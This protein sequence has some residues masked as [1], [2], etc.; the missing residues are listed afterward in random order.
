MI[1]TA[2]LVP[3][4]LWA[5]GR[6][7]GFPVLPIHLITLLWTYSLQ[8]IAGHPEIYWYDAE[9]ISYSAGCVVMYAATATAVWL[10][11]AN[12]AVSPVK[13]RY[14]IPERRGFTI[15]ALSLAAGA[16]FSVLALEPIIVLAPGTFGIV[17]ATVLALASIATFIL[18][19]QLGQGALSPHQRAIF[20]TIALFYLV[21]QLATLFL[22][23]SIIVAAS[24][25]IGFTIGRHKVPWMTIAV[26]VLL[27]GFLHSGKSEMR[28]RYWHSDHPGVRIWELPQFFAE[29][30]DAGVAE[31]RDAGDGYDSQPIHERV[32]LMH[33]LLLAQR[34]APD[35][36]PFLAGET[37]RI[38]PRLLVPRV[39]AP[40]K[41]D[42]HQGT[43]M[44]N[45]HF[46]LQT[47]DGVQ[48]TTIGWGLLNEGYA[49]FGIAGVAGVGVVLGLIFG[50]AGRLTVGAPVMSLATMVG[51]TFCAVALQSEFTMAVFATVLF[52][53][54]IVISVL[55]PLM[56]LRRVV[57]VD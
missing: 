26:A 5:D 53:S 10:F 7:G 40:D 11:I 3:A 46:G 21:V 29:W 44:L 38:I 36:V 25:L 18:A 50:L 37:Y 39:F 15:F 28:D 14:V 34:S 33:L 1:G 23:G 6:V 31:I 41:P 49:N 9:E 19:L 22:I 51:V 42:S 45:L 20:L 2:A 48:N 35:V 13:R 24:L 55:L 57:S 43:A 4:Y 30:I 54:L 8:L 12:R 32:S 52:Q 17:R 47:I 16:G 27:F 56:E